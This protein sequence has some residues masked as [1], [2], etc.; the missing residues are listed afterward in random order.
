[1]SYYQLWADDLFKK[2][3]FRDTLEIIEKLG[4]SG[5]MRKQREYGLTGVDKVKGTLKI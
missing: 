2:A 3:E 1:L 4:H 5:S